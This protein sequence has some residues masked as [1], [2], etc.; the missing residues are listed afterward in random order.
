MKIA[1]LTNWTTTAGLYHDWKKQSQDG[2]GTWNK[3][4]LISNIDDADIVVIINGVDK[5]SNLASL[6]P[7]A[8]YFLME[9]Y[10]PLEWSNPRADFNPENVHTH[11]VCTNIGEWHIG[12]TYSNLISSHYNGKMDRISTIQ[13]RKNYDIGH[14]LR[15]SFIEKLNSALDCLDCFGSYTSANI[16][17]YKGSLPHK[18][19]EVGLRY[20]KYHFAAENHAICNYFTEK[21]I[22]GIL[23]ECLVFYWGCPNLEEYLPARAFIRLPLINFDDDIKIIK[24]A[25]KEN[26]WAA[27]L[28]DI[29]AAKSIILNK[30][31]FFPLLEKILGF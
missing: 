6:Y 16:K 10:A 21:I 18:Q 31:Q 15:L 9:P 28:D 7:N 25:I 22:D 17:H 3:I 8:H 27:R 30:L 4:Q 20:Y 11:D 26:E 19:K 5:P 29:R 1:V 13:S 2:N 23:M 12:P 14:Q 24:K